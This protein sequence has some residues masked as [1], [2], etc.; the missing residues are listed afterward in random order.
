MDKDAVRTTQEQIDV[1]YQL[2]QK[3]PD[4]F[5]VAQT[6]DETE[7][8]FRAGK[9]PSLMGMEG[10]HQIDN[11]LASLRAFRR[12]GVRYMTLTHNCNLEWAESCCPTNN[13]NVTGLTDFGKAVVREMNRIGMLVDISHASVQTMRDALDTSV[14]PLIFSHSNAYALCPTARNVSPLMANPSTSKMSISFNTIFLFPACPKPPSS[15]GLPNS[16]SQS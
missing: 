16:E 4:F 9:F 15:P 2:Q 6:A 12:Q 14:S 8:L 3:Y 10:G 13:I 11:S 1:V 5:H 7:S